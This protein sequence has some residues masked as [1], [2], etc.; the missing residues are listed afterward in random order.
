M[1]HMLKCEKCG[2]YTFKEK[3]SCGG[4]AKEPKPP[5]YSPE[6]RYGEYRRKAK[7]EH[8]KKEGLI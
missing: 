8:L 2:K 6:D 4:T 3:C 1:K 5:K 7:E